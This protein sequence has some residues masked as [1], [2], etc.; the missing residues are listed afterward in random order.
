M[1]VEGPHTCFPIEAVSSVPTAVSHSTPEAEIVAASHGIR[2][3]GI[4]ALVLWELLK[5]CPDSKDLVS[6]PG[7]G[8]EDTVTSEGHQHDEEK[9]AVRCMDRYPNTIGAPGLKWN[10]LDNIMS[11]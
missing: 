2:R 6:S 1:N 8:A 3:I 10:T 9:N 5:S 4:P 11:H 7:G